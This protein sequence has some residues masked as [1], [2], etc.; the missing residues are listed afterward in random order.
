MSFR[1][2]R[3]ARRFLG[4]ILEHDPATI[5]QRE[6]RVGL[7]NTAYMAVNDMADWLFLENEADW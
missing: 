3:S 7:L 6:F 2:V 1:D 5:D 4:Q